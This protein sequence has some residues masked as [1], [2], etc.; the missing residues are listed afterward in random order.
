MW[1]KPCRTFHPWCPCI[2]TRCLF[3]SLGTAIDN[4]KKKSTAYFSLTLREPPTGYSELAAIFRTN[5][6]ESS[7]LIELCFQIFH[8]YIPGN[9]IN[10]SIWH[11]II[12]PCTDFNGGR[13]VVNS[14][15]PGQIGRHFEDDIFRCIFVNEKFCILIKISLKFIP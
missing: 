11:V 2:K 6:L 3:V 15:P 8:V 5:N 7:N 10:V 14:S 4:M 12:H 1:H 13:T 9:Y